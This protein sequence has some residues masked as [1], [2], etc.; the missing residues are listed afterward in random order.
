MHIHQVCQKRKSKS[1]MYFS[2]LED[3]FQ[4]MWTWLEYYKGSNIRNSQ[5]YTKIIWWKV[6]VIVKMCK[7]LSHTNQPKLSVMEIFTSRCASFNSAPETFIFQRYLLLPNPTASPA[8]FFFFLRAGSSA[9]S[10]DLKKTNWT[11]QP[12][13]PPTLNVLTRWISPWP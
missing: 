11:K 13:P 2:V 10:F 9:C 8:W 4:K 5:F 1:G 3:I 6:L 12:K 7:L